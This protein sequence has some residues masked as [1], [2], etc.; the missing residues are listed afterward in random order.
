MIQQYFFGGIN[1]FFRKSE[2]NIKCFVTVKR[3]YNFK[4]PPY[5]FILSKYFFLKPQSYTKIHL[6]IAFLFRWRLTTPLLMMEMTRR[7]TVFPC[8]QTQTTWRVSTPS[9]HLKNSS[10]H[11]QI[12]GI[13][14]SSSP[15]K[16][17]LSKH[18]SKIYLQIFGWQIV[19]LLS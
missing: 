13:Q 18:R 10:C 4:L 2:K 16:N 1:V 17:T 7:R 12:C 6:M 15:T 19:R 8:N 14:M 9:Q 5:L 11:I 3:T